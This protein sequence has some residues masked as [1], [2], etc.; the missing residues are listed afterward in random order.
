[1]AYGCITHAQSLKCPLHGSEFAW[2]DVPNEA[3]PDARLPGPPGKYAANI[4]GARLGLT[5][6]VEGTVRP[7]PDGR[8]RQLWGRRPALRAGMEPWV[9]RGATALATCAV[10][11]SGANVDQ[12]EFDREARALV[13]DGMP[14]FEVVPRLQNAGFVCS[15][16]GV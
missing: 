4:G 11:S 10:L 14:A 5:A 7:V 15:P 9:S 8:E 16:A 3:G 6:G 1:M 13:Q 2:A 12:V